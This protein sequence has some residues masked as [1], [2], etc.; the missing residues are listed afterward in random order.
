MVPGPWEISWNEVRHLHLQAGQAASIVGLWKVSSFKTWD[1]ELQSPFGLLRGTTT[2]SVS[3]VFITV[4]TLW[5]FHSGTPA[6]KHN[7]NILNEASVWFVFLA[8][9]WNLV[10]VMLGTKQL[11]FYVQMKSCEKIWVNTWV[12]WQL[13]CWVL[14]QLI[15]SVNLSL[16]SELKLAAWDSGETW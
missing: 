9:N 8:A 10:C 13:L 3:P 12:F 7:G 6:W 2:F 5:V 16:V 15:I 11:G 14:C 1:L 4:P